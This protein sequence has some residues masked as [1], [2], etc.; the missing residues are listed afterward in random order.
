VVEQGESGVQEEAK[1]EVED[2][3]E[4]GGASLHGKE[5]TARDRNQDKAARNRLLKRGGNRNTRKRYTIARPGQDQARDNTD[6]NSRTNFGGTQVYRIKMAHTF[7]GRCKG[8]TAQG[9]PSSDV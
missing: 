5:L 2:P 8:C 7:W 6:R 4:R 9:K 3:I 1:I